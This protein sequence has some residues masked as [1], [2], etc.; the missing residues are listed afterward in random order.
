MAP[1]WVPA[2]LS[3]LDKENNRTLRHKKMP[4]PA[5]S[6]RMLYNKYL[7][8]KS[9][10]SVLKLIDQQ[11]ASRR[12]VD[13]PEIGSFRLL[14]ISAEINRGDNLIYPPR[15]IISYQDQTD[16]F[17]SVVPLVELSTGD[18]LP[19]EHFRAD[20]ERALLAGE[21]YHLPNIG[22]LYRNGSGEIDFAPDH[23]SGHI[24]GWQDMEA[25]RFVP[26]RQVMPLA[27]ETSATAGL[28]SRSRRRRALTWWP[29]AVFALFVLLI[30]GTVW[31]Q[32]RVIG[33][34][35]MPVNLPQGRV[36]VKPSMDAP[37]PEVPDW[38]DQA[39]EPD[40]PAGQDYPSQQSLDTPVPSDG[41]D[42]PIPPPVVEQP[43]QEYTAPEQPVKGAIGGE[44]LPDGD[45]AVIVG[46]FELQENVDRMVSRLKEAGYPVF[47]KKGPSLTKIGIATSC[48]SARSVQARARQEFEREAWIYSTH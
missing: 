10:M 28:R 39:E 46:S 37:L 8:R 20:L 15:Q 24:A 4:E 12:R 45:C 14:R 38:E 34:E 21:R 44:V 3:K 32:L 40:S 29:A 43:R 35:P 19:Y 42:R 7:C 9:G 23:H 1:E 11:L 26:V 16:S 41:A 33:P 13:L 27:G 30:A 22:E 25:I 47:L 2:G 17:Y 5:G 31:R 48:D 36:N 6:A 18:T